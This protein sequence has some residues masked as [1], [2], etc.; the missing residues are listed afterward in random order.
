MPGDPFTSSTTQ[1]GGLSLDDLTKRALSSPDTSYIKKDKAKLED[2]QRKKDAEMDPLR[3]KFETTYEA[4]RLDVDKSKAAIEPINVKKWSEKPPEMDPL[5]KFFSF[6]S[7]FGILAS[8][9]THQPWQNMMNASAAAISASRKGDLE[10]YKSA[11]EAWKENAKL[12]L[13]RHQTQYQDYQAAVSKMQTDVT[14]G[15]AMLREMGTKYGDQVALTMSEHGMDQELAQVQQSRANAARGMLQLWP[16]LEER[17]QFQQILLADPDSQ[18]KDP[19]KRAAAIQ[20]A[21][22]AMSGQAPTMDREEAQAVEDLVRGG[23][24]RADAIQKVKQGSTTTGTPEARIFQKWKNEFVSKNGREPTAEEETKA[25]KDLKEADR[26]QTPAQMKEEEKIREVSSVLDTADETMASIQ[27]T[28]MSVGLGGK[29]MRPTETLGNLIGASDDT[30]RHQ[31]ESNIT[32]L[33]NTMVRLLNDRSIMTSRDREDAQHMIRGLEM[34]STVQNTVSSIQK[35]Q[36]LIAR[37][38]E[39][40]LRKYGLLGEGALGSPGASRLSGPQGDF[41]T[42]GFPNPKG[43][44]EGKGLIDTDTGKTVAVI[45]NGQ[46]ARPDG[47]Q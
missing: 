11:Y 33:R 41:D 9:F 25:Y 34:G 39:G 27:S 46:W 15:T 44:P 16:Q 31:V 28:A 5:Q 37:K 22:I 40:G 35:M 24:P 45:R 23:M 20:R 36:E 32:I 8:S 1:I 29:A 2:I 43:V 19:Q 10:N 6:G 7:A 42:T 12:M 21:K 14:A 47:A 30:T 3:Q 13:E 17:A 26:P 4:D 18:S 38:Y